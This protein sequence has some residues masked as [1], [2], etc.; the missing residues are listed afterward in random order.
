MHS[1]NISHTKIL[2]NDNTW[3]SDLTVLKDLNTHI[4]MQWD[5]LSWNITFKKAYK[6]GNKIIDIYPAYKRKTVNRKFI[7]L[8]I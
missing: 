4:D 2:P 8:D 3:E 7:Y 1:E 6:L 5:R